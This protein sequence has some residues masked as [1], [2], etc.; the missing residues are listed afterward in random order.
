MCG[1]LRNIYDSVKQ[2]LGIEISF[3][4]APSLWSVDSNESTDQDQDQRPLLSQPHL[5]IITVED[6]IDSDCTS[7]Y[8]AQSVS[9]LSPT[10]VEVYSD[11]IVVRADDF[12]ERELLR[13]YFC[14][15]EEIS[16]YLESLETPN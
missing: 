14:Y 9:S 3:Q 5:D 4:S 1:F 7:E 10:P 8:N 13:R 16:T 12:Y 6:Y 15:S 2:C 11:D